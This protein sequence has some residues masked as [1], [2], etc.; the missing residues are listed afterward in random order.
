[1]KRRREEKREGRKEAKR[2]G[3]NKLQLY[4]GKEEGGKGKGKE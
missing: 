1:M 3:G 4:E 2:E